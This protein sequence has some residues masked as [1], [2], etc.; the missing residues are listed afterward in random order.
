MKL[1][2]VKTRNGN[3]KELNVISSEG[4]AMLANK[5]LLKKSAPSDFFKFLLSF[6]FN[7]EEKSVMVKD[8]L[9]NGREVFPHELYFYYGFRDLFTVLNDSR[10]TFT[11]HKVILE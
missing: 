5:S 9:L 6:Q 3:I 1:E 10:F 2:T 7:K 8:I 11:E 4:R